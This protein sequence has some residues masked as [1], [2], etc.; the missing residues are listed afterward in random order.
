[1]HRLRPVIWRMRCLNLA[2]AF[3]DTLSEGR[4]LTRMVPSGD[5]VHE[6][7]HQARRLPGHPQASSPPP[8][9]RPQLPSSS[10]SQSVTIIWY[11]DSPKVSSLVQGTLT[12]KHH[13]HAGRTRMQRSGFWFFVR[14]AQQRPLPAPVIPSVIRTDSH[15]QCRR[16]PAVNNA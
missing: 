10:T 15:V 13:A 8:I 1:M 12:P 4:L 16:S 5:R 6:G 3:G 9:T 7:T 2:R 14:S 11:T